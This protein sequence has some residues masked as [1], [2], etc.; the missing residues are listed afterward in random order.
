MGLIGKFAGLPK[1]FTQYQLP[2]GVTDPYVVINPS[3]SNV[4]NDTKLSVGLVIQKDIAA[5][6]S[7]NGDTS[8]VDEIIG[9]IWGMLHRQPL[10]V[11]GWENII[12][13]SSGPIVA[14]TDKTLYGRLVS[15][16]MNLWYIP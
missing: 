3:P 2:Q 4:P 11:E 6:T 8:K 9:R 16:S 15:V 7:A 13:N 1:V 5:Y 12:V 10:D 14:P